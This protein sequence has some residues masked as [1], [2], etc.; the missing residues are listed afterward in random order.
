MALSS[1]T[2]PRSPGS[3]ADAS[4]H[5]RRLGHVVSGTRIISPAFRADLLHEV[6]LVEDIAI[7]IG[8]NNLP[9]QLPTFS[10]IGSLKGAAAQLHEAMLGLGYFEVMGW[11]LVN[12]RTLS[13]AQ[14][15]STTSLR[16]RNPLTED[17][18]TLRPALYPNL[19]DIS[20]TSLRP[21]IFSLT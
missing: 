6:D 12:E 1:E 9:V 4:R 11:I 17:F 13:A 7:S 14:L 5:L 2:I 8:L 19:L 21:I 20:P 15:D 10:S 3:A 18:T 16:V